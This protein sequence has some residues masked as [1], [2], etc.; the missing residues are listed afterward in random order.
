MTQAD[1]EYA[2]NGVYLSQDGKRLKVE[3][4]WYP[5]FTFSVVSLYPAPLKLDRQIKGLKRL[6]MRI[7]AWA[8]KEGKDKIAVRLSGD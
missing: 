3:N 1:V 7:P 5:D 8:M 4:L 6:E 2:E